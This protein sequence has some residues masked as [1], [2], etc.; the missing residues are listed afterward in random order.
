MNKLNI[1][2]TYLII[3]LFFTINVFADIN[4][5]DFIFYN[6]LYN[7]KFW[8]LTV[9][10]LQLNYFNQEWNLIS[11][12]GKNKTLSLR[13]ELFPKILTISPYQFQI[14]F[15]ENDS[16]EFLKI[17]L[18]NKG[19]VK[20]RNNLTQNQIIN[21]LENY[22]KDI[23]NENIIINEKTDKISSKI[24][25]KYKEF[26]IGESIWS[27]YIEKDEF[28]TIYIKKN[29]TYNDN[30]IES[31]ISKKKKIDRNQEK[32][33]FRQKI[34][35][36]VVIRANG[37]VLIE[38]I[39]M[40]DQGEKGYCAPASCA[41][42][43]NYYGFG[44]DEHIMA[45]IMGTTAYGTS[46]SDIRN[47]LKAVSSGLPVYA[48]EIDFSFS[49]IDKYIRSGI[50]VIWSI[51]HPAHLRLITGVNKKENLIIYSDSWGEIGIEQKMKFEKAK[52]LTKMLA[53]LK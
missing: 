10:K 47:S 5:K 16:P 35:E 42:V 23:S 34:K 37:D 19:D 51:R 12:K 6:D 39:P 4:L 7:G 52:S 50:P 43:M 46:L 27:F 3:F 32:E 22:F 33:E 53:V 20:I 36:N 31:Y 2:L 25:L 26:N 40:I 38:G 13:K 29:I 28:I 21:I 24:K 15:N 9:S 45:K 17:N 30:I 48:K 14:L 8:D 1:F 44:G 49:Q 41:R 11:G 18:W